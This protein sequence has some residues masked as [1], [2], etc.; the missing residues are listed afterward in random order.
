MPHR[1]VMRAWRALTDPPHQKP[2]Y[3]LVYVITIMT[4]LATL[5]MP[6]RSI[7]GV[8]GPLLMN[9]TGAAW[10]LG[11][12]V[13]LVTLFTPWWWLERFGIGLAALGIA[14]YGSVVLTL[15]VLESG[16]R[17]T[18]LG[19]IVLAGCLF[20]VRYLSIREWSYAPP[21]KN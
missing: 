12:L 17:L 14:S 7:E 19:V 13:C 5:L 20:L 9:V 2:V 3:A 8:L 6:P 11:G 16:S 21:S 18:Q 4:G 10:L 1:L 15:H